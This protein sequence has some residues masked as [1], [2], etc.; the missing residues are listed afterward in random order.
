MTLS[1]WLGAL[2]ACAC[3]GEAPHYGT[4]PRIIVPLE[5]EPTVNEVEKPKPVPART[6]AAVEPGNTDA[7]DPPAEQ[8]LRQ[9]EF[10]FAFKRGDLA[11]LDHRV[12]E[13]AS[14]LGGP[15]RIGRFAVELFLGQELVERVRF[16]FPLLGADSD[17]AEFEKGLSSDALVAVPLIDRATRARLLDRK[18]RRVLELPWPPK[19]VQA[20][21]PPPSVG[22]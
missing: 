1:S 8:T 21:P 11:L 22:Q 5:E 4:L 20:A 7:P 18:T 16:D 9:V 12:I 10:H 15:R 3:S 19:V 2:V 13:E 17:D 6:P 14:P